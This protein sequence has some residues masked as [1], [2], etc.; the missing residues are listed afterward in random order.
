[1]KLVSLSLAAAAVAAAALPAAA[2][3]PVFDAFQK[4]CGDTHADF[5]AVK[6]AVAAGAWTPT[7]V[8]PSTMAG[9]TVSESLAR[10]E[11]VGAT[12]LT[13]YAWHGMNGKIAVSACTVRATGAKFGP[14]AADARAWVG[15]A[16]QSMADGK[17]KYQFTQTAAGLKAVDSTTFNAAAAGSGLELFTVSPDGDDTILDLL[18]IKS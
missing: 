9:V 1:M 12:P 11:R 14:L 8:T 2:A 7:D 16:P 3:S 6:A 18:K 13:V 15:F 10:S 17:A 4:V 5:D